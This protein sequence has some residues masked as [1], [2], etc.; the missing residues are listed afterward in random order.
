[1]H[2]CMLCVSKLLFISGDAALISAIWYCGLQE[3]RINAVRR[4]VNV[5]IF[6]LLY[7]IVGLG[8]LKQDVTQ[9]KNR[10]FSPVHQVLHKNVD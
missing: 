9:L 4:I 1:M 2:G 8:V 7:L 6:M 3:R 10:V 5:F